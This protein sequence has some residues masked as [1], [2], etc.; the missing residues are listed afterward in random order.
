MGGSVL[1]RRLIVI[2]DSD[3]LLPELFCLLPHLDTQPTLD[4]CSNIRLSNAIW[5]DRLPWN[6][7]RSASG[8]G[9]DKGH[10]GCLVNPQFAL[11]DVK[12][13]AIVKIVDAHAV[14]LLHLLVDL[15]SALPRD[16]DALETVLV[17]VWPFL[18]DLGTGVEESGRSGAESSNTGCGGGSGHGGIMSSL[19]T[20]YGAYVFSRRYSATTAH[21]PFLWQDGNHEITRRQIT[22]VNCSTGIGDP[23]TAV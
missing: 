18:P 5:V 14:A 12:D 11:E 20:W 4:V 19:K 15:E 17:V 23:M 10:S 1:R 8:R 6:I 7:S 16:E 2:V 22:G 13:G 3:P 21:N 9:G